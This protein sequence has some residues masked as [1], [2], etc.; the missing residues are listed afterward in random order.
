MDEKSKKVAIVTGGSR[1]IGRA[2]SIELARVGY[3][4]IIN[5]KSNAKA[6]ADTLQAVRDRES[7]GEMIQFDVSDAKESER[8]IDDIASRYENIDVLV[9]NAGITAD[10][11]FVFMPEDDWDAVIN[12]TLKG[13]YNVTK[14]VLGKMVPNKKGAIVSISSVS[15]LISNRG[16]AN[17]SAAKAGLIG[18]SRSISSEVARLGIRVNVVAPGLIET[19]MLGETHVGNIKQMIPMARVGQPEE[20]AKVVRFLCS[21]DASYITGQVIS[22]NGGM[23]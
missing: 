7:D 15:A 21:E 20:V 17:Y 11:L 9:N 3:H 4:I 6:A 13:F 23:F 22:V 16:Q 10:G 5:Y 8:A 1:G 12:T 2:I 19:E 14:P 18:A